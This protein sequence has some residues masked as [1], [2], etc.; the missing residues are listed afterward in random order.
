MWK[1][2]TLRDCDQTGVLKGIPDEAEALVD[3]VVAVRTSSLEAVEVAVVEAQSQVVT[4][5]FRREDETAVS[6]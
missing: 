5:R 2:R 4:L 6:E 3:G 1:E